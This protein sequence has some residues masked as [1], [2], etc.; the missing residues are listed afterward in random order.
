[1]SKN[2]G[3]YT[4]QQLVTVVL[5]GGPRNPR[6]RQIYVT[7]YNQILIKTEC[8]TDWK[9]GDNKDCEQRTVDLL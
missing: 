1:M 6:R 9:D 2:R 3:Q 7:K 5:P 8:D 4:G